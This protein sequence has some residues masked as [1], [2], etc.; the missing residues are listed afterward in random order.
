MSKSSKK[1][2]K[3]SKKTNN[4][5]ESI[6]KR[7]ESP[8]HEKKIEKTIPIPINPKIM[9]LNH[10]NYASQTFNYT[11][12][13][14]KVYEKQERINSIKSLNE[15]FNSPSQIIENIIPQIDLIF[16]MIEKN[17]FRSLSK[18]FITLN[19]IPVADLGVGTS[20]EFI[21]PAWPHL[22]GIYEIFY[23]LVTLD[24]IEIKF[25]KHFITSNFLYQFIELLNSEEPKERE[26]IDKIL[27]SL[28]FK[29]IPKRKLIKTAI[30]N[31]LLMIICENQEFKGTNELLDAYAN[32][33]NTYS[34]PLRHEH[35]KLFTNIII[36]LYKIEGSDKF[37]EQL[38]KCCLIYLSKNHTLAPLVIE[39]L[40]KY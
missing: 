38:S 24:Q 34:I 16:N 31:F 19:G 7:E 12:E 13:K 22:E 28:Y 25:I 40:L 4:I 14:C 5:S 17:I 20:N 10:I 33:I 37:Y 39:S 8:M 15:Y 9:L 35:I 29:M 6:K 18:G 2:V 30:D 11:N 3:S 27:Q 23:K 1:V 21:D 32:I 36:P 26:Y